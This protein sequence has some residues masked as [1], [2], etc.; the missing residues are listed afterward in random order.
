[1]PG[2]ERLSSH[3]TGGLDAFFRDTFRLN[4]IAIDTSS[5]FLA[6]FAENGE[7]AGR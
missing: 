1:M 4:I 2:V 7:E 5:P 6:G 3:G